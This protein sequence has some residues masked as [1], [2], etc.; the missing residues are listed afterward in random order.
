[1]E[2]AAGVQREERA[3]MAKGLTHVQPRFRDLS[4]MRL[5]KQQQKENRLRKE[6]G[7]GSRCTADRRRNT[8]AWGR[9]ATFIQPDIARPEGKK[10]G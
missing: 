2:A 10:A 7:P 5:L 3:E 8:R 9:A 6:S 4:P 1:M